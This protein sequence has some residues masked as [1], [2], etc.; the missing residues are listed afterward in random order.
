MRLLIDCDTGIDDA[1]MLL[2]LAASPEA[3]IVAV[4]SVHGNIPAML[5]AENSRRVL[6]RAGLDRVPV[7]VGAARPLVQ[8]LEM[9]VDVHGRDGLGEVWLPPPG[10]P[11]LTGHS[12]AEQIVGL[13]RQ[14]PGEL[15]VLAT[16]PLTNLALALLLE[17]ELPRLVRRVVVM[18]GAVGVPGNITPVAEANVWHDADAAE[19][20][21]GAGW[22]L[23]LVGLDVTMQT[24]LTGPPLERLATA[25]AE[26]PRFAW[27]ILQFYLDR[28]QSFLGYRG[29]ALHDP[30]AA[31]LALDPALARY[32]TA[33][34]RVELSGTTTRGMTV[35]DRRLF[36]EHEPD[37][38][39][40]VEV[41]VDVDAERFLARFMERLGA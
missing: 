29:C 9:A 39:P 41:A 4:G 33:P 23:T 2:Y 25:E 30:L 7:A 20:V 13:T 24:I 14:A 31:A 15:T 21:L 22:P 34:V 16:G 40:A 32:D 8:P 3:E 17:P 26:I 36:R 35:M 18:G 11:P 5:A 10:V 28:Y 27:H 37:D 38:R 12:A 1:L 19:A 6:E